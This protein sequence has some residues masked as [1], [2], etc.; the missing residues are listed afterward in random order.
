[1]TPHDSSPDV[2]LFRRSLDGAVIRGRGLRLA[3]IVSCWGTCAVVLWC[4]AV[5]VRQGLGGNA[6]VV[7]ATPLVTVIGIAALAGIVTAVIFRAAFSKSRWPTRLAVALETE[8]RDPRL[9]ERLSRAVTFLDGRVENG[10]GRSADAALASGLRRLAI[11]Q[12]AAALPGRLAVPDEAADIKWMIAG[13]LAGATALITALVVPASWGGAKHAGA[14]AGAAV[15]APAAGAAAGADSAAMPDAAR[16]ALGRRLRAAAA[17]ERRVAAVSA[18]LFAEAPGAQRESLPRESQARLDRLAAIQAEVC[19]VARAVRTEI[20]GLA[21]TPAA[22]VAA[23]LEQ[24]DAFTAAGGATIGEAV[25]AN[26]LG[27]AGDR[28]LQA[29][30]ALAGAATALAGDSGAMEPEGAVPGDSRLARAALVL[31]ELAATGAH[32]ADAAASS[33]SRGAAA[34]AAAANAERAPATPA[35]GAAGDAR[36]RGE[37]LARGDAATASPRQATTGQAAEET[38]AGRPDG[39]VA[40]PSVARQTDR[41]WRPPVPRLPESSA[42][43]AL[44]PEDAPPAYRQAVAEY[45]RLLRPLPAPAGEVTESRREPPPR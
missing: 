21:A 40:A 5:V 36:D 1:M 3:A 34:V 39:P 38:V 33:P 23:C 28:A 20:R 2:E 8:R 32:P 27:S 24:L 37:S 19:D 7:M 45:Y 44:I 17:I 26:R 30:A 10:P 22:V 12:A 15:T 16:A 43:P 4:A 18:A 11:E 6:D 9:G 41:G 13:A 35:R 29:A 25:A 42:A 31:D 14:K